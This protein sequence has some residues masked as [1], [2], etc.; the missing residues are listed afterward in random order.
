MP[1]PGVDILITEPAPGGGGALEL[2]QCFMLGVSERGPVDTPLALRSLREY[3]RRY[4]GRSGGQVAHD[5]VRAFFSEQGAV[6]RFL[7]LTGQNVHPAEAEVGAL[8]A[9]ASSPGTWANRVTVAIEGET[10]LFAAAA[11]AAKPKPKAKS[12]K[13]NTRA[14]DDPENGNG[15]ENGNE[16]GDGGNGHSEPV[17]ITVT[18]GEVVERSRPLRTV[19]DAINWS[20]GSAYVR[21][22]ADEENLS[23]SL[24]PMAEVELTGG[25]DDRNVTADDV[26]ASLKRFGYSLGFAQL[27]YPGATD[28]D[29]Q[30]ALLDHGER[31]KRPVLLDLSDRD[32]TTIA[33][34]VRALQGFSG[35][36]FAAAFAPRLIYP[37]PAP[38]TT[39]LVPY[40]AVQAGIIA[41]SDRTTGNPNESA[42]G[43]NGESLQARGLAR[44][45]TDDVR[46]ELNEQGVT[47]ARM[48]RANRV[49]TYGSR[50]VAGPEEPNWTWFPGART[51]LALA[52]ECDN[53]TEEFVHR[54]IDAKR[55]LFTR[56][57]VALGGVCLRYFDM[58]ALYGETPEEAFFVSAGP[59]VNTQETIDAGEV[60]GIVRIHTAPP[61]EWVTIEIQKTPLAQAV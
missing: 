20:L 56:L 31:N 6:M 8:R 43:T 41:R 45:F 47:F 23:D 11:A 25:V 4:G 16:N 15:N 51:V 61:G 10:G 26:E 39:I 32:E 3:N 13:A 17:R 54:Q 33:A 58:G 34:D 35:A 46:E 30:S 38:G 36:R 22:E 55:R 44:E 29:V 2:G 42:A 28:I 9:S 40:S 57:E 60:H 14:D 19:D 50:T 59:E 37:G 53:V 24:S 12:R 7:R 5:S 52:H 18:D 1:R 48:T 27:C 49:R 21:F